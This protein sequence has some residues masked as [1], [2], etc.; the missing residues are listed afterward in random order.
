MA[1]N[2]RRR[3]GGL[4]LAAFVASSGLGIAGC[5]RSTDTVTTGSAGTTGVT[6]AQ[7]QT[8][9][10]TIDWGGCPKDKTNDT[11]PGDCR[12]YVDT[13]GDDICDLSQSDPS[14]SATAV[15]LAS[16]GTVSDQSQTGDC[17]LGPCSVCNICANLG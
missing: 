2:R 9:S 4:A 14:D 11:Y 8:I 7:T 13:N 12:D 5:G 3:I 15:D 16:I 6:A 10:Q 1:T 17:P